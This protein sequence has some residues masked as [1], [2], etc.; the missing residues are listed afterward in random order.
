MA[1]PIGWEPNVDPKTNS[2]I[3]IAATPQ[4]SPLKFGSP[5]KYCVILLYTLG[6]LSLASAMRALRFSEM[7]IR[8][9]QAR[10]FMN[11]YVNG[12]D[13]VGFMLKLP[14]QGRLYSPPP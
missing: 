7:N 14:P 4:K 11:F 9:P 1:L 8:D 12:N 2:K 13:K 6:S 10:I 3:I 5:C